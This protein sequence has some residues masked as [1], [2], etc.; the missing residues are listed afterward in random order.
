MIAHPVVICS[1]DD[2]F[3]AL[4]NYEEAIIDA[5]SCQVKDNTIDYL[6]DSVAGEIFNCKLEEE[7][8]EQEEEQDDAKKEKPNLS[9]KVSDLP[10]FTLQTESIL[11]VLLLF[12]CREITE[13]AKPLVAVSV[14]VRKIVYWTA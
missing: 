1:R 12:C 13:S 2:L 4:H 3:N 5:V 6:L 14:R 7:E 11:L 8:E 10:I 9:N